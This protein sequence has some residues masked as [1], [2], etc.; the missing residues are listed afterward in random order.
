MRTR[1]LALIAAGVTAAASLWASAGTG[2]AMESIPL[3]DVRITGGVWKQGQEKDTE[4][5]LALDADR[6]L[7]PYRKEAGL[8]PKAPNYTNWENTGLDGHIGGHYLSALSVMYASTG[9]KR[10]GERLD[11]MLRELAECQRASGDGYLCGVPDGKKIWAE[12]KNGDIH[13]G[14]FS[15]N[16]G[17]VPLYNIHKTFAGLRD[18]YLEA[19]KQEARPMLVA[20]TDWLAA[21]VKPLTDD[22]VQQMLR[23]EHGGLNEVIADVAAITGDKK[24]MKLAR[25]LTHRNIADMLAHGETD[26]LTG[27]HANTQIPKVIGMERIAI[28]D[29]DASYGKCAAA[30]WDDVTSRRSV[31]IGGNSV[32]E[33]FH[34]PADF[35]PMISSEQGPES[36]NTY[37][38][39]RLSKMLWE[40][41]ADPKYMDYYERALT[42]HILSTQNLEHGGFVYFTPMRPGHYRVYSTPQNCMWC[43]VGTGI[44]NPGR[45]GEAVYSHK[46]ADAIAINLFIPSIVKWE[47]RTLEQQTA[48]PAEERSVIKVTPAKSGERFTVMV[49]VPSWAGSGA[50]LLV[51][52]KPAQA[53]VNN[54]YAAVTRAWKA[55]D[56]VTAELPMKLSA[57]RMPDG[58]KWYSFLYGPTVL[59]AR[60]GTDG[61]TG[62]FAD[63]S[64][65]GH[66]AA[67][68]KTPL[69]KMPAIIEDTPGEEAL[70]R[71]IAPAGEPLHFTLTGLKGSQWKEGVTLEPFSGIAESR[72]QVYFPVYTNGAWRTEKERI[73]LAE[74]EAAQLA[75]VT[76]DLVTCGEQQPESDHSVKFDKSGT[77]DDDG[78]HWREANGSFSYMMTRPAEGG[79]LLVTYRPEK[80]RGFKVEIDEQEVFTTVCDRSEPE[81]TAAIAIPAGGGKEMF[82]RLSPADMTAVTPHIYELRSL[83]ESPEA[84]QATAR[85]TRTTSVAGPDGRLSLTVGTDAAGHPA[86]TLLYDGKP[87]VADSPLGLE[88][89]LGNFGEGM[90]ILSFEKG[91]RRAAYTQ[92]KIKKSHIDNLYN[93]LTVRLG[94]DR[95]GK[96]DVEWAVGNNDAAFRYFIPSQKKDGEKK[97]SIRVD[98]ELSG[99]RFPKG[100][101]AFVTPQSDAM[102]GWKGTKPSYEEY[103]MRDVDAA[104]QSQYG[105]GFT[106]PA[107]FKTPAGWALISETDVDGYYCASHLSDPDSTRLYTVAY[108][109]PEENNGNGTASA[110]LAVPGHTPWRTISVGADLAPVVETTVMWDLVEPRYTPSRPA[111]PGK[112]TWSWIVWQDGSINAAD[113][114]KFIDLASD[115]G[116]QNVLIDNWWD[117]NIGREGMKDLMDY[118]RSKGVGLILWYSSSGDWNDIEQSPTNHMDRPIVRKKEMQWLRDLGVKTIKV[119]FFG[120]DKQQTIRLYEDILSDA[121]DY[122]LDVIFHGCTLPRGWERMYPNFV[123]AEAVLASENLIF[124]QDFCDMEAMHATLHPFIRNAAALMEYGGTLLNKRLNKGNDGGS[125]RRT[126]DGFQIATAVLFQNPVQNFG[127]TPNNLE[128]APADAIEFMRNVPTTWDDV[129]LLGGYPGETVAL[130]RRSGD[131]WYV[132][133]VNALPEETEMTLDLTRLGVKPGAKAVL[134]ADRKGKTLKA[135]ALKIGRPEQ[136]VAKVLP[137]GAWIAVINA[138]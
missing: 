54:G 41:T 33:H 87:V 71:H 97:A 21:V 19:G 103:Y 53:T 78:R 40:S 8:T 99:F 22:Q 3:R 44:E 96:L 117:N 92:D 12:V 48:F 128:D 91:Q 108:P 51:N 64:R 75:S 72:Y 100:T 118:A 121:A 114:R 127:L 61:Q 59:A 11:Y 126:T 89:T 37:N 43:C 52:G 131:K 50:R 39:L 58:S 7:A 132:A 55:G 65:G 23:S 88:G 14:G 138:E 66:I 94:N 67:G 83:R 68:P 45:F 13:A 111:A 137:Q 102:I 98:R 106:F 136:T 110:S 101:T 85:L 125:V 26:R 129:K 86:Y 134:Y 112:G 90:R 113:Q 5:L 79:T 84:A 30:F 116:Y 122:G 135:E 2:T 120:G 124:G 56:T 69:H 119:D 81:A 60:T 62:L 6:L 29:D 16:G 133:A 77:W 82:V 74:K 109:M 57:E 47:G 31:S 63:D 1:L 73:E 104:T 20:L 10:I 42:N 18:A 9:D 107:L 70:L 17:W 130:A 93:T 34:S 76:A 28:L 4:Y 27:M 35:T 32:R 123:G 115:M 15:L 25:R 36:C 49:R 38:M 80:G 24:Y 95:G 105:H 46:G